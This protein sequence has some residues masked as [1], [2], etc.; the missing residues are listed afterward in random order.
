MK[1]TIEWHDGV[2]DNDRTVLICDEWG[3]I[4]LGFWDDGE[5]HLSAL[6]FVDRPLQ[7][8]YWADVRGPKE[9]TC[10]T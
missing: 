6:T 5:W 3:E 9:S 10:V 7:V 4:E 8:T 2:P 1:E